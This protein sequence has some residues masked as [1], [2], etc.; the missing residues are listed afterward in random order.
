MV[1]DTAAQQEQ[2]RKLE[3]IP[4]ISE[5]ALEMHISETMESKSFS[6]RGPWLAVM[7]SISNCFSLHDNCDENM[8]RVA[9]CGFKYQD[10]RI[11]S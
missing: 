3:S 4:V 7:P 5:D 9:I 11:L 1:S 8:A 6:R 10:C 2:D